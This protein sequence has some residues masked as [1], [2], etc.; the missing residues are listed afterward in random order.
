MNVERLL[1]L[2][3][4]S[5][6]KRELPFRT[7]E[8]TVFL[9]PTVA[10]GW[11]VETGW[12]AAVGTAVSGRWDDPTVSL[13]TSGTGDKVREGALGGDMGRGEPADGDPPPAEGLPFTS[14]ETGEV[15]PLL[16]CPLTLSL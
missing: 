5:R 14:G 6:Q 9:G 11:G 12:E 7:G 1:N 16:V 15:V 2:M 13:R 4:Q 8:I 3:L 10:A